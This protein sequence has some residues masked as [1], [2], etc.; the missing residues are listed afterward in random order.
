MFNNIYCMKL[1]LSFHSC[2]DL[3]VK[4]CQWILMHFPTS[5]LAYLLYCVKETN[6]LSGFTKCFSNTWYL[7]DS[8]HS[9]KYQ[10]ILNFVDTYLENGL[11]VQHRFYETTEGYTA[12]LFQ[13]V[14]PRFI[15]IIL[16][17]GERICLQI[18]EWDADN[19]YP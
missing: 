2:L 5:N 14:S 3:W 12:L 10:L 16:T 13:N 15:T 18:K 11:A 19:G 9:Q 4:I 1:F 6:R 8:F 17:T 7:L